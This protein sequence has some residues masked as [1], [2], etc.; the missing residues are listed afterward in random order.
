MNETII[1]VVLIILIVVAVSIWWTVSTVH[2]SHLQDDPM[3][4]RLRAR[5]EKFFGAHQFSSPFDSVNGTNIMDRV[6]LMKGDKS[7]TINK[8][9]IYLCLRDENGLYYDENFLIF[10]VLH[11]IS[12]CICDE[13]GHT[14][15]F[16]EIFSQ[17]LDNAQQYGLY[18]GSRP[19]IHDYCQY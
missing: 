6:K 13:V 4:Y 3:L 11:E 15:K 1:L 10:V 16:N 2:E 19:L 9:N 8:K 18:D 7:Y 17:I 14:E 12:H 5:L